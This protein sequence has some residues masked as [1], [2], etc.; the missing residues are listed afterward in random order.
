MERGSFQ[1]YEECHLCPRDCGAH[2]NA[3]DSGFCGCSSELRIGAMLPHF[4]EEPCL[5]GTRGSGT[6]FFSGCSCGCFFCQN[7]Q[8][9][10]E[11]IGR[12][13]SFDEFV[14]GLRALIAKGV[15]NLNFV[16][17]E[18][19]MPTVIAACRILRAEGHELPFLWNSSGYAKPDAIRQ[20]AELIDVFMPDFKFASAKLAAL[21]MGDAEYSRHAMAAIET[22]VDKTGFLR[23]WDT[24]G[25][26]TSGR[27][28][29]VRHLV[30]PGHADNSIA[31]LDML[32]SHFGPMLPISIMSQFMP[33]PECARRN[34]LNSQLTQQEYAKACEHALELGFTRVFVQHENGDDTFAPDFTKPQPFQGNKQ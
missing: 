7:H 34:L 12:I 13:Y 1:E 30:L 5:S 2:R 33:M 29:I 23:P 3:G 31:A 32:Y 27:G 20:A 9:S 24:S 11:G 21:C 19:Y 28:T 16:T 15:H 17:P 14:D 18:H 22:M 26:I 8:I 6:V 4:G 10:K 25:E